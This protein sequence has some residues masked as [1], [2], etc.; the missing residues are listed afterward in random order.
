ME[1]CRE[2][3]VSTWL[4][5][6]TIIL[7][8]RTT[9]CSYNSLKVSCFLPAAFPRT[10]TTLFNTFLLL[11]LKP[12]EQHVK[13]NVKTDSMCW[14]WGHTACFRLPQ[15]QI[16]SDHTSEAVPMHVLALE[17][18]MDMFQIATAANPQWSHFRGCL[19]ACAGFGAM[20]G[21]ISDRH[22]SKSAVITLQRLSLCMCRLWSHVWVCFRWSQ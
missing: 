21:Y 2:Y 22:S 12:P 14:Y 8:F 6:S 13:E 7:A 15:Q 4:L 3:W 18:N 9:W 10:F 1:V 11:T 20:C 16:C 19:Y 17:P 5:L